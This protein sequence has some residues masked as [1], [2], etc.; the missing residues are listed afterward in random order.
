M[1]KKVMMYIT[2]IRVNNYVLFKNEIVRVKE[3]V[4][5]FSGEYLLRLDNGVNCWLKYARPITI[6]EEWLKK[7]DFKETYRSEKIIRFERPEKFLKYDID[8]CADKSMEGLMIFG[9][10]VGCTKVHQLQNIFQSFLNKEILQPEDFKI[11]K[12]IA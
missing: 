2:D 6:T 5:G 9:N 10:R 4:K 3:I 8:L 12:I 7:L 11:E 1:K